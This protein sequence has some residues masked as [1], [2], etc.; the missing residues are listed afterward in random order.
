VIPA[1]L[2]LALLAAPPPHPVSAPTDSLYQ[3]TTRRELL[4]LRDGVRVAVTWWLPAAREPG[5][6]FPAL[7]EL[8][9][10]RKDDSFYARDFPLYDY[11]VRRGF[12]LAKV[13][14]RGTGGSAG[15]V[16]PREYSEI[17]LDDA[18][19]L[20]ARL[21]AHPMSNGSV[22]MWGISWGGFNAIQVA[23]RQPPALKAILALHAADDLFHDDVHY[24]DGALHLDPY[25][26]EIDHE[27]GLPATPEYRLDAAYFRDRFNA[28]PWVLTYLKQ[29]VDGTFWR[30]NGLR[31]RPEDLRI[32]TYFIGGLLDGYRD[33]P[34]RALDYLT[35]APVKVEIGPWVH[36]WPDDGTPGPNY[37]WRARA[38]EWWNHWL[39]GRPAPLLEEPRLLVFQRAGHGPDRDLK[40]TPGSWRF[41]DWPVAGA[42]RD[43]L[44]LSP[45][46]R[47]DPPQAAEP[48]TT[49]RPRER[50]S[51]DPE[52]RE[53]RV[54]ELRYLPGFGT[55]AG[56]WWGEPTGDLRRDDAGS[57]TFDTPPLD[58]AVTLLGLP[59]VRLTV[60]AGAPL[61]NWTVRLEDVA[62]DGPVSLVTGGLLNGTQYRSS[63]A[64]ERLQP[65]RE[66]P[67]ELGL[68]FTTWTFRPGHRIR[69]AVS[70]AQFPMAWPT[71]YPMT[72][73]LVLG[74]GRSLVALPVV[75]A[76]S[77]YP[78]P[79]LPAPEPR[80]ERSNV[81]WSEGPEPT[82]RISYEPHSGT[83]TME[84]T[85][86]YG[87][88]IGGV[89]I[90]NTERER[91]SVPDADP[92]AARFEGYETH[93]IRPPGRDL[94]LETTIEIH[95]DSTAFHVL[96]RRRISSDGAV[97]KTREWRE[98]IPREFH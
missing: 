69:V 55:M 39:R 85:S 65:G 68:H 5:E 11:F 44:T 56:D 63:T 80:R 72:T 27:N 91:Y 88:R 97:V 86:G 25:I 57:L 46:G 82:E 59:T 45:G 71:P 60:V 4:T 21:A 66:Y 67:L 52:G 76:V 74:P 38:V 33:T 43:T 17:E 98:S 28:Y 58:S 32:P 62:P 22:G 51:R 9:P 7:L 36:D 16:P 41:E 10:Y 3:Y 79:V 84:W 18:V 34:I 75:P 70:N 50:R 81:I 37:E 13:D 49:D 96:V 15:P 42:R 30:R 53:S 14:I 87:E 92:A 23:L 6:R 20:I 19:E 40:Q 24:V 78:A 83:T 95:S 12:L 90:E 48:P 93:R 54:A 29:P 35:Q 47:L 8:L 94:L 2:L 1:G 64:P 31:F 89:R 73:G 77:R 61:A 26:L